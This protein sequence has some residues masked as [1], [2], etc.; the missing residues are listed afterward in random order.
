MFIDHVEN[1]PVGSIATPTAPEPALNGDPFTCVKAPLA[2]VDGVGGNIVGT[3][4]VT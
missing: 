1:G 2:R 4:L 3:K